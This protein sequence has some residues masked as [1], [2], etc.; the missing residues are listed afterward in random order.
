MPASTNPFLLIVLIRNSLYRRYC[1]QFISSMQ[2]QERRSLLNEVVGSV[3][4]LI[5]QQF[6]STK[7]L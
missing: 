3:P 7:S 6:D 5:C 4:A 1:R 2:V